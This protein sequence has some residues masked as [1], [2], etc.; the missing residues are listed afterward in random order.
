MDVHLLYY[1]VEKNSP[2]H[3]GGVRK[4]CR[5]RVENFIRD[6]ISVRNDHGSIFEFR[7]A[8]SELRVTYV[9]HL[10][11]QGDFPGLGHFRDDRAS[12]D[13]QNFRLLAQLVNQEE[14]LMRRLRLGRRPAGNQ[15]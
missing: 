1:H 13:E 11:E 5:I 3:S 8:G 4:I 10:E 12:P 7:D 6:A 9:P 14:R 15:G 2:P